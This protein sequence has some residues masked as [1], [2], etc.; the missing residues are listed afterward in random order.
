MSYSIKFNRLAWAP[1]EPVAER[2]D[3]A[4]IDRAASK[5][6]VGTLISN[7]RKNVSF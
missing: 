5:L 3:V 1:T 7:S 4:V 2:F 6:R